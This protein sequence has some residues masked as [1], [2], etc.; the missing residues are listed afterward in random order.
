MKK[1]CAWVTSDP[2][3]MKYHDEEWGIPVYEDSKLFEM[4]LLESFQA[5]LS[6]ITI[7]KKREN[8]RRAFDNFDYHKI[9]QYNAKKYAELVG[10]K[11]IVRNKLKI[12]AAISNAQNFIKIRD[13]HGS[14]SN[15]LWKFSNHKPIY[16]TFENSDKV[17]TATILSDTISKE[18]QNH[19]FQFVGTTILY[20]YLQA[21]GMVNNH[22]KDCFKYHST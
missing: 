5:G 18:L 3:Y 16:N 13:R 22:T 12:K 7:L 14:F 8:F 15:F 19:G 20:A 10:D 2:L 17:P 21:M 6:W 1:R 4:L 11:G 9:A